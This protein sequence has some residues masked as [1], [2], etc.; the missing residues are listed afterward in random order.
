MTRPM[1]AARTLTIRAVI[2]A[3]PWL[4]NPF[5][6]MRVLGLSAS[7]AIFPVMRS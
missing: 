1:T 7:I 4:R 3:A 5:D 6:R 2:S